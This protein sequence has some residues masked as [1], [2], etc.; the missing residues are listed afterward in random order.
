MMYHNYSQLCYL[1]DFQCSTQQL[2]K[3]MCYITDLVTELIATSSFASQVWI[4]LF[5][6]TVWSTDINEVNHYFELKLRKKS[7]IQFFSYAD[8]KYL[9]FTIY[10]FFFKSYL[11]YTMYVSDH[12]GVSGRIILHDVWR[13]KW[14]C[15]II[16]FTSCNSYNIIGR[17]RNNIKQWMISNR[18]IWR[19]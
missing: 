15:V 6:H 17:K 18:F 7:E 2:H 14:C 5:S 11:R 16:I 13:S 10:I 8:F 9:K 12:R 1:P 19:E 3:G 4:P